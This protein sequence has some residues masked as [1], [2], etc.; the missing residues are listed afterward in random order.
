MK[1]FLKKTENSN[2]NFLNR[3]IIGFAYGLIKS[4][5]IILRKNF[6]F[7][8]QDAMDFISIGIGKE[9]VK[10][11][12]AQNIVDKNDDDKKLIGKLTEVMNLAE[13]LDVRIVNEKIKLV[14]QKCLICPKRI[15]GYDLEGFTACPVGGI[16]IGALTHLRN[17]YPEIIK[18]KLEV[19]EICHIELE[20]N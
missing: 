13:E 5:D 6:G 20:Y 12:L 11:L 16:I 17:L 2:P 1:F 7:T 14:V 19:A 15:G 8:P 3:I 18:S 9:V 4:R 10:E